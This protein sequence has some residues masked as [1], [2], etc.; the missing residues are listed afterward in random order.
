MDADSL[1]RVQL[2]CHILYE[3][4]ARTQGAVTPEQIAEL[5]SFA[6]SEEER[7][8]QLDELARAIV[9]REQARMTQTA[10]TMTKSGF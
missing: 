2:A 8:M 1:V 9:R 5:R 4:V 6:E 7:E 10:K 3:S